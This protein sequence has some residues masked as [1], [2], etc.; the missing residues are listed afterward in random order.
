MSLTLCH[1]LF[2]ALSLSLFLS[3]SLSRIGEEGSEL[4]DLSLSVS[5]AVLWASLD[6]RENVRTGVRGNPAATQG[7]DRDDV[8]DDK[9]P[10]GKTLWST[11]GVEKVWNERRKCERK[12]PEGKGE[13]TTASRDGTDVEE[14]RQTRR[15]T[16]SG[17]K[18]TRAA[19]LKNVVKRNKDGMTRGTEL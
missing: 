12:G 19:A 5:P 13:E 11:A 3:H 8:N 2:L 7:V 4:S 1:R 16:R 18:S 10:A 15:Q 6:I 17:R 14:S 9:L